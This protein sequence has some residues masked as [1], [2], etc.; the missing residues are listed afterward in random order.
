MAVPLHFSFQ[1]LVFQVTD[2]INGKGQDVYRLPPPTSSPIST[3]GEPIN[4]RIPQT[5]KSLVTKVLF[6]NEMLMRIF[7]SFS[8]IVT[9]D[10]TSIATLN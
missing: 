1:I 2:M 8:Y 4:L 3:S 9:L 10:D 7:D 5:E 6:C